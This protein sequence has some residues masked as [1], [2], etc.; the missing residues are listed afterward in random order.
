MG[1]WHHPQHLDPLSLGWGISR[2][3]GHLLAQ[4]PWKHIPAA[5]QLRAPQPLTHEDMI[6]REWGA[7]VPLCMAQRR[8]QGEGDGRK[9]VS[10]KPYRGDNGL[11]LHLETLPSQGHLPVSSK[12]GVSLPLPGAK[13]MASP[14]PAAQQRERRGAVCEPNTAETGSTRM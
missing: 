11:H 7:L 6:P 5:Q 9:G 10:T 13:T 14:V 12:L 8:A 1:V 4:D 3:Q 2:Q